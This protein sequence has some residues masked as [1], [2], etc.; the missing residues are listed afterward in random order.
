MKTNGSLQLQIIFVYF[1]ANL[2]YYFKLCLYK[3]SIY[4]GTRI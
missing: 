2:R 1:G 4:Y 3:I